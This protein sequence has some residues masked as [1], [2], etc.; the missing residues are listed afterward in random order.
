MVG[1]PDW[2]N[3]VEV[4][5]AELTK[6]ELP[7]SKIAI[8]RDSYNMTLNRFDALQ[9]AF[10][11]ATFV[12][13]SQ[14]LRLMRAIKTDEEIAYLKKASDIADNGIREVLN[15]FHS[16]LSARDCVAMAAKNII[17]NG[18][19]A[20]VIGPV[21]RALDDSKMHALVDD[22]PLKEGDLLHVEMIPQ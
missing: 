13:M 5:K 12:D 8:D 10:P 18:G 2:A 3:P 17:L 1:Y 9:A 11:R 7:H 6:R 21:T 20:G 22:D 19:D 15:E 14:S 4:L 16:G